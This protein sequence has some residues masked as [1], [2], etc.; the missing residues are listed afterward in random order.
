M[1]ARPRLTLFSGSWTT[2][3]P[4]AFTLVEMLAVMG[5]MAVLLALI[6]PAATNIIKGNDMTQ[7]GQDLSNQLALARQQA[8]TLNHPVEV[9]FYQYA[10]PSRAGESVGNPSTWKFRAMQ[11]FV[12]SEAGTAAALGKVDHF[13]LTFFIDS[14]A[15]LSPII[16]NAHPAGTPGGNSTIALTSNPGPTAISYQNQTDSIPTTGKNYNSV[17]FRFYPDGSTNISDPSV[18][19]WF[20]TAHQVQDNDQLSTAPHNF[21]TVQIDP[22]NG[23]LREFRP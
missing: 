22:A 10:D 3:A 5:I 19:V 17:T 11:T 7:G 20:L 8:L 23:N 13:P 21:L 14:G 2:I 12:I 6:V 16:S 18:P 15:T 9:R 1:K 4:R